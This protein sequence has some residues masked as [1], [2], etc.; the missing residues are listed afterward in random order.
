MSYLNDWRNL[1]TSWRSDLVA[2]ITVG[3]VALPLALGFALTTG[4]PAS[5]GLSTAIIAGFIAALFGGSNYQVSG[6]TG[7]MT[8]VLVPIVATYGLGALPALGIAAGLIII[9]LSL[10]RLGRYI[11]RVPLSV[12]EGFTLGIALII[13]LQQIPL[14]LQVQ[15]AEGSHTVTV[16]FETLR[17]ALKDEIHWISIIL[18]FSTLA[19]KRLWPRIKRKLRI[20]QHM[21]ASVVAVFTISLIAFVAEIDTARIGEL[22]RSLSFDFNLNFP[23]IPI[24]EFLYAAIVIA[25]LGAIESLLS[26]RVADGLAR[27]EIDHHQSKHQPNKE[28]F[29]QGLA[30]MVSVSA[31][32]LPAT[33]AIARTSVNV[34]AGARTR[35]AA[36]IHAVFLLLVVLFLAPVVSQ[37]PTSVLAGVL[38]GTSLRIANPRSVKEALQTTG[39][40]RIVYCATALS[41]LFID[42]IWGIGIGLLANELAKK[43][44]KRKKVN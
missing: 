22:P 32:G 37:I 34:H 33:G 6:P 19:L 41:V 8:V 39:S 15:K 24:A 29:G 43:I 30:T 1:F 26:A 4:A 38:L 21:P 5:A 27:Q 16:A 17:S 42:L 23:N 25:M 12:M 18:A 14:I 10:L 40:Q 20:K 13:A 28:L 2:G 44:E 11:D 36:M 9:A 31:G 3:I 35:L 7:A